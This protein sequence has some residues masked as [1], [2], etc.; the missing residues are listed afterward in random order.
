MFY[1]KS[2]FLYLTGLIIIMNLLEIAHNSQLLL[3]SSS[4][5]KLHWCQSSTLLMQFAC[6]IKGVKKRYIN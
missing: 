2:W 3:N 1:I 6:F 5:F 4:D